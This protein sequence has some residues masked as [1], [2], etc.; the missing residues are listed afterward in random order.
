MK[1]IN[2]AVLEGD[3]LFRIKVG[4]MLS[5]IKPYK[6][7]FRLIGI[8]D[9]LEAFEN[10]LKT[11]NVDIILTEIYLND[12]L[13]G[14]ELSKNTTYFHLPMVLMTSSQNPAL[15][16]KTQRIRNL[17]YLVKP[18]HTITLL[19]ALESSLEQQNISS[20]MN[21][22]LKPFLILSGKQGQK[23]KVWLHEVLYVEIENNYATIHTAI[24]KYVLRKTLTKILKEDLSDN[25]VRVHNKYLINKTLV[26][27]LEYHQVILTNNVKIPIG[28]SF[29]KT[30]QKLLG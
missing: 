20:I 24:K 15:Y 7:E 16:L 11:G 22:S 21:R 2:I 27:K 3:P 30:T 6:H 5:E 28:R 25:F 4:F 13:V 8:Y 18:F 29:Q 26:S 17:Q 14:L 9:D 1:K 23:E 19:S 10:M 12:K